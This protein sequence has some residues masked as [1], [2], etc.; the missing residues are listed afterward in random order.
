MDIAPF[1]AEHRLPQ[2]YTSVAQNWFNPMAD[3]LAL[4]QRS[5]LGPLFVGVN[6][7]QGSGKSTLCDYL[8]FYLKKTKALSVVV[9]SIDDFYLSRAQ[10]TLLAQ[11]VHP[12]LATRGVPGTHDTQQAQS[13]FMALKNSQEVALPRFDKATDNPFPESEWPVINTPA[14]IVLIEGWCWGV[15]PQEEHQLAQPVNQLEK[16]EDPEGIWRR[17]VNTQLAGTYQ[18]LFKQM[19]YWAM[20]K[21]P[22]FDHV[23]QWR[24]EQEHKL[25]ARYGDTTN[26]N[27][28]NDAQIARFIQHYQRLTEHALRMLPGQCDTVFELDSERAITKSFKGN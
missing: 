26:S 13:T 19:D 4:R 11:K 2:S 6:G 24:C 1:I 25:A 7:S 15:P 3:E 23:Y 12:L 5:A 20:L 10:R 28:M 21:A 14:D 18:Q 17:F 9:L 22:S 8:A 16:D 27:I